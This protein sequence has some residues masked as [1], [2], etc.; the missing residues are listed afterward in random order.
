MLKDNRGKQKIKGWELILV[1]I[2][3]SHC[4]KVYKFEE[5]DQCDGEA[6]NLTGKLSTSLNWGEPKS[7]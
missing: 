7:K 5:E 3:Q 4:K 1:N 2:A 6:A